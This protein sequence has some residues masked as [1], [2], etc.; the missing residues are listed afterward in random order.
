MNRINNHKIKLICPDSNI[1]DYMDAL[2]ASFWIDEQNVWN[3][4]CC[5]CGGQHHLDD[6]FREPHTQQI[7]PD[8]TNISACPRC[9]CDPC[10]C[11]YVY[12]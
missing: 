6:M 12:G 1:D 4:D 2:Q 3:V 9:L 5:V 11:G 8:R 10:E 7:N